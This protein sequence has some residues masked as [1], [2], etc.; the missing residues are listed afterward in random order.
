[1]GT[2]MKAMYGEGATTATNQGGINRSRD[3][4]VVLA[5]DEWVARYETDGTVFAFNILPAPEQEREA[6]AAAAAM[7]ALV[8]AGIPPCPHRHSWGEAHRWGP[9]A[10]WEE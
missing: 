1:M 10:G 5:G 7:V 2:K 6:A 4:I 8:A 3:M 9:D